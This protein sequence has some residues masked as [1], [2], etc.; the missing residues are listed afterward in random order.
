LNPTILV[1]KLLYFK[2]K[3]FEAATKDPAST[4][5]RILLDYIRRNRH[6][7]YGMKYNFSDIRS[8][9]DYRLLVP[10][11]DSETIFPYVEKI[12]SGGRN[13]LTK[14]DVIFFGLTSGT[15]GKPKLIPVTRFSRAKKAETMDLWAYYISRDHPHILNGKILALVNPDDYDMTE[16]GALVGAESGHAYRNM[17]SIVKRFYA[18]PY[19]VFLIED[20]EAKYY[21]ILRVALAQRI[22]TIATL[23][24]NTI[25]LLCHKIEKYRDRLIE[26]IANGTLDTRIKVPAYIRAALERGFRPDAA[27]AEELRN[28]VKEK[29]ELLPKYFW[30]DLELIECWKGGTV[31]LYLKELPHYFGDVPVRDFGCL[32]TEA[33]SSIPMSDTGAGGVLAITTN[34]YEFIP[35]EDIGRRDRRVLLCDE[36]RK[37]KEYFIIVTTPGGLYRYNIDDVV[38][39]DGFF[40][41]TPVIEFI[42]KG[43]SAVSVMGEKLYESQLDAAVN[44][45]ADRLKI[46]LD[47]FSACVDFENGPRYIF[48]AEF[49]PSAAHADRKAFLKAV[50]QELCRENSEYKY[51]RDSQLLKPPVLKVVKRGEFERYRARRVKAGANDSQ[52]KVPELSADPEFYKNFA[53]EEEIAAE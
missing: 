33:R 3:R 25:V 35:K 5:R 43:L 27:R 36:L 47:F 48:L 26:D 45:A 6:T 38:K 50:E 40:N 16:G 37:G 53:V 49:A 19:E 12:R 14:D 11:N 20:Y 18:V 52:F 7:E 30:P 32:S 41:R 10:I 34:F 39:V 42:Q 15:T 17:P 4:Q 51:T 23:N 24:P 21:C 46:M 2:A 29:K 9:D 31:K 13:I 22:T 28:I 44:A 8:V 1:L